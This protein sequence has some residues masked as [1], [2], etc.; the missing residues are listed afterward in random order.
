MV[1]SGG[2]GAVGAER[3]LS[4]QG[5]GREVVAEFSLCCVGFVVCVGGHVVLV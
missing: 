2:G 3:S 4:D 5:L 1:Q